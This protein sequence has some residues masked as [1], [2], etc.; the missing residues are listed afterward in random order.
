[1]E[2]EVRYCTAEDGVRIAYAVEGSGPPLMVCP[3]AFESFSLHHLV[4]AYQEFIARLGKG[5]TL[6][7]YDSRGIGL[8]QRDVDDFTYAAIATD[9]RA[10]AEASS[11]G[12]FAL[13]AGTLCGPAGIEYAARYPD[14]LTHLILYG[15]FA[16]VQAAYPADSLRSYITLA[17]SNWDQASQL[18]ADLSGRREFPEETAQLA[19][20][21]RQST[22]AEVAIKM[23]EQA[24]DS[25]FSERLSEIRT[26]TLVLHRIN[27]P[28]RPL[29]ASREM[30]ARITDAR[31]V[32]LPGTAHMA[33]LGDPDSVIEAVD[34]F[35]GVGGEQA[36]QPDSGTGAAAGGF[37]TVIVTDIVGHTE[38]MARLGDT[39]GREVLREHEEITREALKAHGGIEL[40]TMGD[41]FMASFTSVVK[42]VECAIALQRAFAERNETAAEPLHVRVGL[43]A[44]EPIEE[45][46]PDGRTDLFGE[47]V[48]LASRIAAKAEGSEVLVSLA[49][50]E[51]CAGKGFLFADA[52]AHV[53][54]GFED[55]VHVFAVKWRE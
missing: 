21:F 14:S 17:A 25:D 42:A 44:G 11:V 31:L 53:M 46:G 55:P 16:R 48:I 5:R 50:R 9:M 1:M 10:V 52:G 47:T 36:D 15:T 23:I 49:V 20:C 2:R 40:K 7:L 45:D 6:V 19:E 12:K 43:S 13:W 29:E 51:L 35:L 26:P 34:A 41:G 24:A 18:F 33:A 8:S 3:A 32:T 4:P 28:I 54:R 30:A 38:M 22:T 37:R 27:D 39:K